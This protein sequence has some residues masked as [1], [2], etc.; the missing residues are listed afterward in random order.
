[1]SE[2]KL[3]PVEPTAEMNDAGAQR[4]ARWE[5]G[6]EWPE[7]WSP[8]QVAAMRNEA[9]RVWRSMCLAAPSPEWVKTS[10]R[11]PTREDADEDRYVWV[12]TGPPFAIVD[13]EHIDCIADDVTH[14]M[15]KPRVQPPEPP[16]EA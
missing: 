4:L 9:E 2:W 8:L 1:M 16:E 7:S 11:L 10:D 3:V 14:W 13:V 12:Y 5:A 6:C 15:P